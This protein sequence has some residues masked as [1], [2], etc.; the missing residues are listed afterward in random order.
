[1]ALIY[2]ACLEELLEAYILKLFS[3]LYVMTGLWVRE[4]EPLVLIQYHD[5]H[6][7]HGSNL[8]LNFS[9]SR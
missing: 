4:A 6:A 5:V 7:Y 2:S 1:M 3:T 8:R 9:T